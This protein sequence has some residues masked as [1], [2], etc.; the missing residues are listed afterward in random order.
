MGWV[1]VYAFKVLGTLPPV[2]PK[3][4]SIFLD[5]RSFLGQIKILGTGSA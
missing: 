5:L 1:R 2:I 4:S 3:N